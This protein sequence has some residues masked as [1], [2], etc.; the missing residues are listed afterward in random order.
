MKDEPAW[1]IEH[2]IKTKLEELDR[3]ERDLEERLSEIREREKRERAQAAREQGRSLTKKRQ[4]RAR[5]TPS[6][7]AAT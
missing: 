4:V 2:E 1:V 6:D 3:Q 5:V 7:L